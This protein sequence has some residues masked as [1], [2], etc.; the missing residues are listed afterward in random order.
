MKSQKNTIVVATIII[1]VVI[2]SILSPKGESTIY[3]AGGGMSL[4]DANKEMKV[5]MSVEA[6][7]TED[8]S[9]VQGLLITNYKRSWESGMYVGGFAFGGLSTEFGYTVPYM[10]LCTGFENKDWNVE[11]KIGKFTRNSISHKG[12]D[13]QYVNT[14]CGF[15]AGTGNAMQI[16]SS[17]KRTGTTL[18]LGTNNGS[19]FYTLDG[20]MFAS[21]TQSIGALKLCVGADFLEDGTGVFGGAQWSD[22]KNHIATSVKVNNTC[23]SFITSYNRKISDELGVT[24][25]GLT[26]REEQLQQLHAVGTWRPSFAKGLSTFL[27]LGMERRLSCLSPTFGV[28]TSFSF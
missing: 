24:I 23:H 20:N 26:T 3:T 25:A 2:I 12:F 16:A 19:E 13:P 10:H 14:T 28:G 1:V 5:S 11:Y 27:E 21:L 15:S 18:S 6:N 7:Q 8:Q 22:D 9:L 17:F 4:K